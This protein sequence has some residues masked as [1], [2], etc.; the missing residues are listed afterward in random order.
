MQYCKQLEAVRQFRQ[1][2]SGN[3]GRFRSFSDVFE[4]FRA[5]SGKARNRSKSS[6]NARERPKAPKTAWR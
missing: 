2:V 3:F 5:V 1:T 4:H 6:T